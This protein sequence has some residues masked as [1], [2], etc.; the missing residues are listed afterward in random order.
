MNILPF[1]M[2]VLGAF[3]CIYADLHFRRRF[4]Y[5]L[6][7]TYVPST[8]IVMLSWVSFWIDI[9]AVPARISLGL[10]TVLTITT[11]ASGTAARLP[12]VSYIKALDAWMVA[13]LIFVFGALIEYSAVNV[14]SRK[15]KNAIQK[16]L[17]STPTDGSHWFNVLNTGATMA[18]MG[19]KVDVTV[20]KFVT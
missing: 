5:H 8:L 11:M 12:K 19:N 1:L 9:E 15:R 10:L 6:I 18:F 3:A 14:L 13:C 16:K 20:L 2:Y 4:E 7:Q 17:D